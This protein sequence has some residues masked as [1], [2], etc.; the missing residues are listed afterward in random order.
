MRGIE[1]QTCARIHSNGA[2]CDIDRA[3]S[4][5]DDFQPVHIRTGNF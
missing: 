2:L 4:V 1:A 3:L 5:A